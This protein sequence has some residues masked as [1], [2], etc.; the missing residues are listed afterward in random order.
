MM[1][2]AF[3]PLAAGL[4]LL[5]V[6]RTLSTAFFLDPAGGDLLWENLFW[7]FGHPEVYIIL[8]PALGVL[9]EVVP[10]FSRRP[11]Y[12]RKYILGAL[13]A[14]TLIS[15]IVWAHHMF[16]TT[17]PPIVKKAFSAST[18]AISLPF[19]IVAIYLIATLIRGNIRFKAPMLFAL[20]SIT[21]FVIGGISGVYNASIALNYHI[22]GTYWVVAHF[23]YVMA[24]TV[25]FALFAGLYYWF[26]K[27]TGRMYNE[28]L[29]RVHFVLSFIGFNLL[30]FPMF[31]L[32]D[33]PMRVFTYTADTGW[34][35]LNHMASMGGFIFGLSQLLLYLNLALSLKRGEPAGPNPWGAWTLEWTVSSP[36]PPHNFDVTPDLTRGYLV[37]PNGGSHKHA[38]FK[39]HYTA[40]PAV[41]SLGVMIA[42]LGV[43]VSQYV[44]VAGLA[45]I[46]IAIAKWF[47]DDVLDKF[48]AP[49]EPVGER[50]PF[51]TAGK[52][53][54]GFWVFLA[55]EMI[56]FGSLISAY[57]FIRVKSPAWPPGP[58][59]HDVTIGFVNTLILLTSS[60]SIVLALEALKTR[61]MG[62]FKLALVT[63]FLL[64]L[65]FLIVKGF[66]WSKLFEE[67]FVP[68][69]GLPADTYYAI[70]GAHAAHVIAGLVAMLY[71]I[72]KAF[73]GRFSSEKHVAVENFGLYWHM[74]DIVW[75]F[76][77]PLFYLL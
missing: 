73:K 23:H 47:K 5:A 35:L 37:L 41:L 58:E 17:I 12:G 10:V 54:V 63:T 32:L 57:L 66:E 4:V 19:E 36:P 27:M 42:F 6:D 77:F 53:K 60:F 55:S 3:P 48:A 29:A 62:G 7:F 38:G 76:L 21:L 31:L 70:T 74:V 46:A 26:P 64:G 8:T 56:L 71:L 9:F 59:L 45:V 28:K 67:G 24:G 65:A 52:E 30:Y 20:G 68:G 14:A 34:G 44:L 22:R 13:A 61:D 39:H 15:F 33:M 11:L 16:T 75:V 51:T 43:V 49:E 2:Y 25:I 50:W 69:S 40:L 18:I 1:L 72:L